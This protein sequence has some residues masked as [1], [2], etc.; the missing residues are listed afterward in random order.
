MIFPLI[1]IGGIA[2]FFISSQ[3]AKEERPKKTPAKGEL[4]RPSKAGKALADHIELISYEMCKTINAGWD[5][6]KHVRWLTAMLVFPSLPWPSSPDD[7]GL[8]EG[9][10]AE[11][12]E[13]WNDLLDQ[14]EN[15]LGDDDLF[16]LACGE[17]R[18]R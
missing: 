9:A 13:L 10:S 7:H 14:A 17:K 2:A 12:W 5:N 1:I 11:Q 18:R 15:I 16:E 8:P 3:K 6:P 4:P